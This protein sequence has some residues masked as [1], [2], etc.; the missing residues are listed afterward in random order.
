M[1]VS[2]EPRR[3][4][5]RRDRNPRPP[6]RVEGGGWR[7]SS[8]PTAGLPGLLVWR[9]VKRDSGLATHGGAGGR[10]APTEVT[11]RPRPRAPRGIFKVRIRREVGGRC[12]VR[13][14]LRRTLLGKAAG[15]P[16]FPA[17]GAP[18]TVLLA[19]SDTDAPGPLAFGKQGL[20]ASFG[21]FFFFFYHSLLQRK[22][23]F[24]DN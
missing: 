11:E 24:A 13:R 12:G 18:N 4:G 16:S 6:S 22:G 20:G 17:R 23:T 15:R 2:L 14:G 9:E 7:P 19:H 21:H 3:D 5:R 8:R 1:V 10:A